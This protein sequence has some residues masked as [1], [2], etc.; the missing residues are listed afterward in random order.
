MAVQR[1]VEALRDGI[2]REGAPRGAEGLGSDCSPSRELGLLVRLVV[3]E[4]IIDN[5]PGPHG[6]TPRDL[7]R[8]WSLSLPLEKDVLRAALQFEP[9]SDC[10]RGQFQQFQELSTAVRAY[11]NKSSEARA[12]LANRQRRAVDLKARSEGGRVPCKPGLTGPWRVV[13]VRGHR[14][15]LEPVPD[16]SG[17]T[18]SAAKG[19]RAEDCIL[20]PPDAEGPRAEHPVVFED[21][22]EQHPER[23]SL[24]QQV[25]GES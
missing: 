11:W 5:T 3:A 17:G 4:Y 20:V 21:E 16:P 25:A 10:A 2:Q 23:P 18:L 13:D 12:R 24:G 7:E 15:T 14:L 6:Y 22:D 1:S 8:S 19:P 9:V